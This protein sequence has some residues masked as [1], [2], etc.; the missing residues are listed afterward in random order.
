V[1]DPELLAY[2][3]LSKG[4][5]EEALRL[6]ET[7]S[8]DT[9]S[10]GP[11]GATSVFFQLGARY[12][13]QERWGEATQ[14]YASC[15]HYVSQVLTLFPA[16]RISTLFGLGHTHENLGLQ[17]REQQ[18][19]AKAEAAFG[20]AVKYYQD[21]GRHTS[22]PSH[23]DRLRLAYERLGRADLA[24]Q[25]AQWLERHRSA[26]EAQRKALEEKR[27]QAREDVGEGQ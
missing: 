12:S 6:L 25:E 13:V 4:K 7:A 16:G 21:A 20:K 1:V 9:D 27:R 18:Q 22:S 23:H 8:Q 15:D 19:P 11:A 17:L 2:A 10:L 3:C 26:R 24:E 14:A 5:A